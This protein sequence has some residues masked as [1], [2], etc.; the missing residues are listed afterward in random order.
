MIGHELIDPPPGNGFVAAQVLIAALT[1]DYEVVA[2]VRT[3]EKAD[4]TKKALAP[5]VEGKISNL[6]FYIVPQIEE[7]HAFDEVV[8][9]NNF[10]AVIHTASPL[11][12]YAT[13]VFI[14]ASAELNYFLQ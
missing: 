14:S 9:T 3:Q 11:R 1:R 5:R 13:A 2:T 12:A 10:T 6:S 7:D 4:Q 8:K